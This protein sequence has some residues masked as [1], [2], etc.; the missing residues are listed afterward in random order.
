MRRSELEYILGRP[1]R[2]LHLQWCF[3]GFQYSH[4][5]DQASSI[6]RSRIHS[7]S[8]RKLKMRSEK[9]PKF[10]ILVLAAYC[11]I[12]K[13]LLTNCHR[14]KYLPFTGRYLELMDAL[15]ISM[16]YLYKNKTICTTEENQ[17]T[18][19]TATWRIPGWPGLLPFSLNTTGTR[20]EGLSYSSN[21]FR[22]SFATW[23]TM[24]S[25]KTPLF[26]IE[27]I[28]SHF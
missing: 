17:I 27:H 28:F 7:I 6:S 25:S 8:D 21:H 9:T 13:S 16:V 15:T 23:I 24:S 3:E 20:G 12:F 11:I 2:Q 26:A 1:K 19:W 14:D 10:K 18:I 22:K 5:K 4:G